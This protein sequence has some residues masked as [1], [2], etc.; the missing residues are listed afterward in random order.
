VNAIKIL[1]MIVT[2]LYLRRIQQL[3]ED[4]INGNKRL[5]SRR[6]SN[7]S[8]VDIEK[9]GER[10]ARDIVEGQYGAYLI[11]DAHIKYYMVQWT[12]QPWKI[13]SGTIETICVC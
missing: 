5:Q 12:S 1:V 10:M 13:E 4:F 6:H 3:E 11:D 2:I 7:G 8:R 9:I